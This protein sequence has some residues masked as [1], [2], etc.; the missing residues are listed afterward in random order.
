MRLRAEGRQ[1]GGQGA[2]RVQA[3]ASEPAAD[4]VSRGGCFEVVV[5]GELVYSKLATGTFPAEDEVV[6]AVGERLK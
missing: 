1:F 4:P 6:N 5:N 3:E 2:H